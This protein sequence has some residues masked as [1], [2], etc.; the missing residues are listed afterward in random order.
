M[1]RL[2][3]QAGATGGNRSQIGWSRLTERASRPGGGL[4]RPLAPPGC[5]GARA[6]VMENVMNDD[7]DTNGSDDGALFHDE[8]PMRD[9]VLG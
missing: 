4:S 7:T 5:D 1:E 8:L 2:W 9:I 6:G 3:S